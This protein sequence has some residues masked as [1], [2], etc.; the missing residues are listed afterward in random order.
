MGA[1][2]VKLIQNVG[3]QMKQWDAGSRITSNES[4]N[5]EC[6]VSKIFEKC[7]MPFPASLPS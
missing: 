2:E 5:D 1:P 7:L 4:L 6:G 3:N